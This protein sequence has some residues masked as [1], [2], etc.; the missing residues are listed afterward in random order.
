MARLGLPVGNVAH[1]SLIVGYPEIR[2]RRSI[3]RPLENV[4]HA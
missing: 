4:R 2:Y 1:A 3:T